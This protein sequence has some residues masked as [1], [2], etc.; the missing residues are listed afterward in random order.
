MLREQASSLPRYLRKRIRPN[1]PKLHAY[2]EM[3]AEMASPKK[4]CRMWEFELGFCRSHLSSTTWG[5]QRLLWVKSSLQHYP[6][7][8]YQTISTNSRT[9]WGLLVWI[10][11]I[12]GELKDRS[13]QSAAHKGLR[14][15]VQYMHATS[16]YW[17]V[18]KMQRAAAFIFKGYCRKQDGLHAFGKCTC[19]KT[20]LVMCAGPLWMNLIATCSFVFLQEQQKLAQNCSLKWS[21]YCWYCVIKSKNAL[22]S[23]AM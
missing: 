1:S 11:N 17:D 19:L 8:H 20:L 14:W 10:A 6:W 23:Q 16:E 4:Q 3:A 2:M 7:V 9:A 18:I 21:Q 12:W 5:W 15:L 13:R 22:E